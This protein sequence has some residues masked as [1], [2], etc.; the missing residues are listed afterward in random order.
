MKNRKT[1][2]GRQQMKKAYQLPDAMKRV[3]PTDGHRGGLL[4]GHASSSSPM[5]HA[6]H[7]LPDAMKR[8][9]PTGGLRDGFFGGPRFVVAADGPS[10][11][12]LLIP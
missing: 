9:P 4:E 2:D 7:Q 11:E 6:G 10:C 12:S 1:V 5:G 8:V 3:P